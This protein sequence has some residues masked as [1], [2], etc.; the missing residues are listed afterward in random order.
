MM[1]AALLM[2]TAMF[3]SCQKDDEKNEPVVPE[4]KTYTVTFEGEYFSNLIDSVQYGGP[5]IY[6]ADEYKWTDP[7]TTLSSTCEKADWTQW[8]MGYGWN[9]G[10]AISNYVDA[11]ASSFDKQLSV[12]VS[13]GSQ[14]FAVVWDNNSVI[15]FADSTARVIKSMDVCLTT[16]TLRNIQQSWGEGYEFKVVATATLAD[17]S[18]KTTDIPLASGNN[19][20]DSWKKVSLEQLGAVKSISFSFDGT[21]QGNYGLATPKYF[22]FDNVVVVL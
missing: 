8:G 9:N 18:T 20:I 12:P 3:T 14:N 17:G 1:A 19:A 6:S 22:A 4:F 5:L 11:T 21:D 7:K 15:A 16:Y 2:G 10:I 13:N